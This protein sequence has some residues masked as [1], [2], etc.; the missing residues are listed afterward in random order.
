MGAPKIENPFS[1][2]ALK[3]L[4]ELEQNNDKEWFS[5]NK[6]RYESDIREPALEFIRRMDPVIE[7]VSP[8]FMAVPKKVGG[9]LMRVY[10]DVRFSKDKTP[11]KTNVG[12]QFRHVQGK[13]VHAPGIY[14]H[15][16]TKQCFV[17][18]GMWH[19]DRDALHAVRASIDTYPDKWLAVRDDPAFKKAFHLAGDSLSRGPA[20]FSK[21]HPMI[22][23]LKRK[24]HIAVAEFEAEA[25]AQPGFV[26][27]ITELIGFTKN[28][29]E[30]QTK[31][32]GLPF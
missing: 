14:V 28:Y 15:I 21:D 24:D 1:G 31:A 8:H 16:D 26:D 20:G 12:I 7:D 2:D 17:G 10:R 29:I 25:V 32:V 11:Y 6:S 30:W 13:D 4:A 23:D 27:R 3:F 5:A 9:S 19:P 22:E 18:V